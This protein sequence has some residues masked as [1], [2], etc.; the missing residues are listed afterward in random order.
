MSRIGFAGQDQAGPG[1]RGSCENR[2]KLPDALFVGCPKSFNK[3]LM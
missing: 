2:K 1:W 3:A